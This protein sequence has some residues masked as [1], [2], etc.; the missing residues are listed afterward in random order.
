MA[1]LALESD[2]I[3]ISVSNA[4]SVLE[5]EDF[6]RGIVKRIDSKLCHKGIYAGG[7]LS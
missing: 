1:E 2:Q 6:P 7:S 3:P 5:F 4:L